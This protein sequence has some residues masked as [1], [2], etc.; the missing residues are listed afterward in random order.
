MR[1]ESANRPYLV[2]LVGAGIQHSSSPSMHM[3]EGQSLGLQIDYELLDFDLMAVFAFAEQQA[4]QERAE[5][6][7]KPGP[8]GDARD[9]KHNQKS[10]RNKYP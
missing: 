9:A 10:E 3:D 8:F 4:G 5:R 6:H 2:G 7:R 1:A